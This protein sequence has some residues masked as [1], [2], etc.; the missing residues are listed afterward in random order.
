[1]LMIIIL[2]LSSCSLG[3]SRTQMLDKDDFDKIADARLEQVIEAIK[4]NDKD[5]LKSMFSKQALDEAED[6]DANMDYL[7]D[8][9]QGEVM[10]WKSNGVS[11]DESI[12]NG[13]NT[14]KIDSMYYLDTDKQKYIFYLIECIVDTD[15]SDN[16][17]LY[18]LRVIKAEN[19]DTQFCLYQD[20]K[21]GIYRPE[22][23]AS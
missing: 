18:T 12:D 20:M 5:A 6:F 4:N 13:H 21:A 7:F 17:G 14:K 19:R 22:E 3:G 9:F 2:I 1:M 16:V 23:A 11:E 10:S 15:H 8:F